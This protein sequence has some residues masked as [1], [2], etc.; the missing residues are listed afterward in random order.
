LESTRIQQGT[1]SQPPH[2]IQTEDPIGGDQFWFM[3]GFDDSQV[4]NL[5]HVMN[6]DPD[7]MLAEDHI[8]ENSVA[9]TISWEQW[10][11]WLADSNLRSGI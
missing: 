11:A 6:M 5:D 9:P 1:A 2:L 10:D 8:V 7:F 3:N 4:S